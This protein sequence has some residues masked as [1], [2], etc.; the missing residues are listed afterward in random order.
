MRLFGDAQQQDGWLKLTL[1][2][3]AYGIAYIDN[4][5]GSLPVFG[6]SARFEAALFGS[7]CCGGAPADGFS[8][9]IVPKAT[10]LPNPGYGEPAEEGLDQGLSINFDTWDNGGG[11]G[12]AIEVKWLGNVI[13]RQPFQASQSP[14]GVATDRNGYT[15]TGQQAPPA[16]N[17]ATGWHTVVVGVG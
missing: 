7:L 15:Q 16:P 10:V 6:F 11:E 5:S 3:N 17:G 9:N 2:N 12:P 13:A 8:F 1:A 4:F 14:A